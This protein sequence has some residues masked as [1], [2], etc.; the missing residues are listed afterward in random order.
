V[1]N[2]YFQAIESILQGVGNEKVSQ[3]TEIKLGVNL[4]QISNILKTYLKN[5]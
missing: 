5:G 4:A 1:S 3:Q 2:K